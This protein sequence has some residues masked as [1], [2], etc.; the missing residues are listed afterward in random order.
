M[1]E[2]R[3]AIVTG[4][5]RGIG[6]ATARFLAADGWRLGL[7]DIC[8]D[9]PVLAYS[10]GTKDELDGTAAACGPDPVVVA[11]D[12]RDPAAIADAVAQVVD[13]FGRVDAAISAVGAIAGG[14]M[15]WQTDDEVWAAMIDINLTGV[16]N[17]VRA[18]VPALLDVDEA[19]REGRLVVVSSAAGTYGLP[20]LAAYSAAK[21]GVNGLVKA[22]AA[23]LAASGVTVNA[24]SPGSTATPML[25]AS[26]SVYDLPAAIEFAQH[27]RIGRL[28]EPE[29]VAAAI[30]WLCS[31]AASGVTG[32]VLPVDGGFGP[33][34]GPVRQL[35]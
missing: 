18:A 1:T 3:V 2:E 28:L 9:D 5:A 31:G 32:A 19:E 26:A 12:V 4:A 30:V 20:Q 15:G 13:R 11:A 10:L 21:H 33:A 14:P 23:E 24:V 17:L 29:E 8:T 16:W 27:Q 6:S 22:L 35:G 34:G 25:D 7:V